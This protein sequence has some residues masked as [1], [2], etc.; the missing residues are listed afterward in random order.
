MARAVN[1]SERSGS[2]GGQRLRA[3]KPPSPTPLAGIFCALVG[4]LVLVGWIFNVV[5]LKQVSPGMAAM[6]PVTAI[7]FIALGM[8]F[9]YLKSRPKTARALAAFVLVVSG[10]KLLDIFAGTHCHIDQLLF[11]SQ[12]SALA[13]TIPCRV[14]PLTAI[15]FTLFAIA[16]FLVESSRLRVVWAAHCLGLIAGFL[17]ILVLMGYLYG[18]GPSPQLKWFS[19]T[20][21]HT[22]LTSLVALAGLLLFRPELGVMNLLGSPTLGGLLVRRLLPAAFIIPLVLGWIHVG[23]VRRRLIEA[24]FG[25]ALAGV[26]TIAFFTALIWRIG[27]LQDRVHSLNQEEITVQKQARES[28]LQVN[29]GLSRDVDSRRQAERELQLAKEQAEAA[30]RSK[31]EFLANMSHEIRTPMNGI[32]GMIELLHHGQLGDLEKHYLGLM[33]TSAK[34]LLQ[35]IGDILDL[36]KIEAGKMVLDCESFNLHE[37]LEAALT[38]VAM[39]AQQKGLK[40]VCEIDPNVP[41]GLEGDAQ[42]LNQIIFN[43][44][45][46]AVKFTDQGEIR[47]HVCVEEQTGEE[48]RLRFSVSDTGT[49]I[50]EDKLQAVFDAFTQVDNS[51]TRRYGGTGLGLAICRELVRL[52]EGKIHVESQL[53]VGSKFIFTVRLKLSAAA[54]KATA[55][56]NTEFLMRQGSA[57]LKILVAEDNAINEVL[58]TE[59]L[60]QFGHTATVARN[61][62]E[63]VAAFRTEPWDLILMDV[64]MPELDGLGATQLIRQIENTR[65]GHVP[66]I[67]LTAHAMSGDRERCLAAGMDEYVTK[68]IQPRE[69]L[70][71]IGRFT[72]A[73][74]SAEA[75]ESIGIVESKPASF[76]VTCFRTRCHGN[77]SLARQVAGLFAE[78]TPRLLIEMR[79]ALEENQSHVLERAAHTL[80]GSLGQIGATQAAELAFELEKAGRAG[81]LSDAA[82]LLNR[83][84]QKTTEVTAVLNDLII[85]RAA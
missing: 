39:P 84:E 25:V 33:K 51:A 5:T 65:G 32:L 56:A 52:M 17:S 27:R 15:N 6:N 64:Q 4:I 73:P 35:I 21:L 53:G 2:A 24:E 38:V 7:M 50:P 20:S 57:A 66:I 62:R 77:H 30:S 67:A 3:F 48:V 22:V 9:F 26:M 42:R 36:S 59:L 49:G 55:K 18:I 71:A 74:V 80:K 81:D 1:R 41:A 44:V 47:L 54:V 37:S 85:E 68:P 78:Q 45:G 23:G 69:L 43:L 11:N 13:T 16:V 14:A 46:N 10:S 79:S 63:A 34:S 31:S 83:L 75:I 72:K 40:F 12:L 76:T 8:C 29:A 19:P 60:T 58:V 28:L 61:G 82:A 70:E